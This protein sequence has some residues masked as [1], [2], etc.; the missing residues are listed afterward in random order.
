MLQSIHS[1]KPAITV[2]TVKLKQAFQTADVYG[3][4]VAVSIN[5]LRDAY[6]VL[7][8]TLINTYVGTTVS[9]AVNGE[10]DV[11]PSSRT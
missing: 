9:A 6:K 11:E 4:F 10:I 8:I 7:N 5:W 1:N 2:D 3:A